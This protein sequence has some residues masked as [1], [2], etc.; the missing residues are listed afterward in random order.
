MPSSGSSC[1]YCRTS[2]TC[3]GTLQ[4]QN[5]NHVCGADS[6]SSF[7]ELIV[8]ILSMAEVAG[9]VLGG[10]PI[11]IWALEKYDEA[12][13]TFSNYHVVIRTL[14]TNLVLQQLQL[15]ATFASMG[16]DRPTKDELKA[17]LESKFG[18]NAHHLLF[19]V[20][21][22]EDITSA[23]LLNLEVDIN[24][25][26]LWT[27]EPSDRAQ[28]E[29]RRVKRSFGSKR[30]EKLVDDLRKWNDDLRMCLETPEVPAEDEGRKVQDLK[31]Q[32]NPKRCNLIR[33][34]MRSFHRALSSGVNCVCSTPHEV[35]VE[36]DWT[37]YATEKP[38][39]IQI[40]MSY[41]AEETLAMAPDSWR[42]LLVT[43]E[44]HEAAAS[45]AQQSSFATLASSSMGPPP[46]PQTVQPPTSSIRAKMSKIKFFHSSLTS[47]ISS[48]LPV[49]TPGPEVIQLTTPRP[50]PRPPMTDEIH[51]LCAQLSRQCSNWTLSGFLR[52]PHPP[53]EGERKF[54][55]GHVGRESSV[56]TE[57]L[58]LKS[59]I[60]GQQSVH[61]LDNHLALSAKQRYGIAAAMSW[62]VLHLSGSAWLKD[63][64][65]EQTKILLQKT[66]EGRDILSSYPCISC[67]L[68]SPPPSSPAPPNTRQPDFSQYVRHRAIFCLG[69]LLIELALNKPFSELRDREDHIGPSGLSGS[70]TSAGKLPATVLGDYNA[71]IG[72][73]EE[74]HLQAGDAYGN[75]A[76]RCVKFVFGGPE[77][78]REF[79]LPNFR[80]EFYEVVVAPVQATY[81]MMPGTGQSI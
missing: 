64:W 39:E 73:L 77:K 2:S 22:M 47:G 42:K 29:W 7:H 66:C 33:E 79:D 15:Q 34:W 5:H 63:Q 68:P 38:R 18:H 75:A 4:S 40:A 60:A 45:T 14:R 6:D 16:L 78:T 36:L 74:V 3:D 67:L 31:R 71:A 11:A 48:Q 20:Q 32:F 35:T 69:V 81:L 13:D 24:R 26:P 58:A 27:S 76:E 72:R 8:G 62:A 12:L 44:N 54:S 53:N 52:D 49:A 17:H 59:V 41:R 21:R 37:A 55:L 23:L 70:G 25:K 56:V 50:L 1:L 10:I 57:P 43:L 80:R 19:V 9:L 65:D 28:W 30:R 46:E 51:S 61:R